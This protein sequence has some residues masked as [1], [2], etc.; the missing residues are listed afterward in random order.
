VGAIQNLSDRD[1]LICGACWALKSN[2]YPR[3][4]GHCRIDQKGGASS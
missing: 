1:A 4:V 2:M 3:A